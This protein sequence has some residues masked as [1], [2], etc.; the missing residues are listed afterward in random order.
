MG[1]WSKQTHN[2]PSTTA[3][4]AN[5]SADEA[6]AASS[7]TA[8]AASFDLVSNMRLGGF[9]AWLSEYAGEAVKEMTL[10]GPKDNGEDG[11][12]V[13]DKGVGGDDNNFGIEK[14][15]REN[16][17]AE[18]EKEEENWGRFGRMSGGRPHAMKSKEK[19]DGKK[20]L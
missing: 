16:E 17:E 15:R 12:N 14:E 20:L 19:S 1:W 7:A 5:V 10:A 6:A 18:D 3:L 4:A 11:D 9:G 2:D 8:G 13:D